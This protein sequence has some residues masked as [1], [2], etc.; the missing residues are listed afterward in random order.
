MTTLRAGTPFALLLTL[1]AALALAP[2]PA[3]A[4]F[5]PVRLRLPSAVGAEV[6]AGRLTGPGPG[7]DLLVVV[8]PGALFQRLAW[9]RD[10]LTERPPIP[11]QPVQGGQLVVG[12]FEPAAAGAPDDLVA[13]LLSGLQV[14]WGA[15]PGSWQVRDPLFE[16]APTGL[17]RARLLPRP[18]PVVVLSLNADGGV[19]A[20]WAG[21]LA[22]ARQGG[23]IPSLRLAIPALDVAADGHPDS[24]V[25][26]LRLSPA[27]LASGVDDLVMP[28]RQSLWLAW[29]QAAPGATLAQ[30][31]LTG[32]VAGSRTDVSPWLAG[33]PGVQPGGSVLGAA[34][35]D[36][37]GDGVPDLVFSYAHPALERPDLSGALL[38][39]H[40][41]GT[42]ASVAASPW[43]SL[44]D[45]AD[46]AAI[47]DP[48]TLRQLPGD[49]P[50][51][52]LFD[53]AQETIFILRGDARAG[54]TVAALPAGGGTPTEIFT[55][56]VVGG[57]A[58]DLIVQATLTPAAGQAP[59]EA[60][61]WVYPDALDAAPTVAFAPAPPA[62]VL[63]G[64][65]LPL[66]VAA[67]DADS[68]VR[69]DWML[70]GRLTAPRAA[71][72]AW[73]VPGGLLC[74]ASGQVEVT[75]RATDDLGVFAEV[76]ATAALVTRPA[77]RLEGDPADRL[78]LVPGGAKGAA[79]G[80]AWPA[81]GRTAT[82]T[83]G[84]VD[85][86]GLVEVARSDAPATSRREFAIPEAAYPAVLAGAPALTLT[87]TDDQG[88]TGQAALPLVLDAAGLVD[89]AVAFDRPAL[90]QGEL[91]L[92][93]A[94]LASR[95]G[96]ALPG[97]RAVV[98]LS[99]LALAGP[100]TA[101]GAAATAGAAAGEATLDA[102]PGGGAVVHLAVPVRGLGRP[103]QVAV[104]LFSSAGVRLSPAAEGDPAG[105]RLPGCGCGAG[106]AGGEGALWPLALLLALA[107]A[108]RRARAA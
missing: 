34:A 41:G 39:A 20:L 24:R 102:L 26:P 7:D 99:G 5:Q 101:E 95:L 37:D 55:A 36:A 94:R 64:Q 93:T 63:R 49:P 33:A 11:G 73:T 90:A 53:R 69:V 28:M 84:E 80:S 78:V 72:P 3:R 104:E 46:L 56:D 105:E 79:T 85:V 10:L 89:V 4:Q 98:R 60:E 65:D 29:H 62:E 40:N 16:Q 25:Y 45:R 68:P 32:V 97:V 47:R 83:W 30:V 18:E 9:H 35:L 15:A 71:G 91:G 42:A 92:A 13:A 106:R 14:D 100:V 107:G 96:V 66:A 77:L 44:L 67:A 74:Q 12:R 27:A 19:A 8:P 75:A 59:S 2:R 17:G 82:F 61:V 23:A 76:A 38:Y 70:G 88:A 58:P 57:A 51:L 21:D 81:C 87:A 31:Q 54:F 6:V 103:G 52:A 48:S 43:R 86:P 108:R 1:S 50:V 22:A